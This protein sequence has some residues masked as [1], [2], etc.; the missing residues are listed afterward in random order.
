MSLEE[1]GYYRR[2]RDIQDRYRDRRGLVQ[3]LLPQCISL[4]ES[5]YEAANKEAAE[6]ITRM[7]GVCEGRVSEANRRFDKERE[8]RRHAEEK[9][10][11]I[12]TAM[13]AKRAFREERKKTDEEV[14]IQLR[15]DYADDWSIKDIEEVAYR[16]RMAGGVDD[17]EVKLSEYYITSHVPD[18]NMIRLDLRD[19][20]PSE[21][22][23]V[24]RKFPVPRTNFQ[25]VVTI[26][27]VTAFL[28]L[29]ALVATVIL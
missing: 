22:E 7:E 13:N 6:Q 8:E 29:I 2:L 10:T 25:T 15:K 28:A 14:K 12:L 20:G 23:K 21:I 1:N 4:V 26:S 18:P 3:E 27:S 11:E 16:L 24:K 9:Y 17:T 5:A 19:N